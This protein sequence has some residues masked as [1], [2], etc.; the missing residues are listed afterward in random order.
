MSGIE[1]KFSFQV[2]TNKSTTASGLISDKGKFVADI[3][4]EYVINAS[5]G[6]TSSSIQVSS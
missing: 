6:N 3:A 4:G 2:S 1:P 5:F